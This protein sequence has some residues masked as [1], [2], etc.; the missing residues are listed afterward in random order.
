MVLS[1]GTL[2]SVAMTS[3]EE[4]AFALISMETPDNR[5]KVPLQGTVFTVLSTSADQEFSKTLCLTSKVWLQL[6]YST[7]PV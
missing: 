7:Q 3:Q 6:P 5:R 2:T 4:L 1:S